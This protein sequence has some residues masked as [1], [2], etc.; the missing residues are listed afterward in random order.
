MHDQWRYSKTSADLPLL[1]QSTVHVK[2]PGGNIN[3][4][5]I[6]VLLYV[7]EQ[8]DGSFK[9]SKAREFVDTAKFAKFDADV[10][11][12]FGLPTA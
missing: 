7:T 2:T 12:E 4:S 3:D 10:K 9:V 6:L 11:K 5:E 1:F 8:P